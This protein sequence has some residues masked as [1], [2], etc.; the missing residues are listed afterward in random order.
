MHNVQ[1][2]HMEAGSPATGPREPLLT[3]TQVQAL[4]GVDRSTVYRMAEDGRLP[5]VKI[6]RQWRFPGHRIER[7]LQVQPAPEPAAGPATTPAPAAP[8]SLPLDAA[9]AVIDVAAELL[10]VMMVV[11]DL[12]GHPLTAVA[13]PCARFAEAAHDPA[14]I[15]ACLDEWRTMAAE[16][17][18]E[19]RFRTG[20]LGFAC[21]R[22]YIRSGD[23]LIGM[24]LAGG[25]ADTDDDGEQ[26]DLYHLDAD[27]RRQVLATLPKV[28][29]A[30]SRAVASAGPTGD[31]AVA[32]SPI[33]RRS[34]Q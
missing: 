2:A 19:P 5:A 21:A 1:D 22:S 23:R 12:D 13:N 27:Q 10:G 16:L 26:T 28:A 17:E 20:P 14:A 32:G 15:A 9:S 25:V 33:D 4:L 7:L 30:L 34:T 3:A 11:T 31:H 6:G 29:T 8:S 18:F 24:V